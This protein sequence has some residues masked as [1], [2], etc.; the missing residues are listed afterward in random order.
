MTSTDRSRAKGDGLWMKQWIGVAVALALICGCSSKSEKPSQS[1][2]REQSEDPTAQ[3]A[4]DTPKILSQLPEFRL[5]DSNND[6]FGSDELL[7]KVWVANFIFTTCEATCPEQ[8]FWMHQLQEKLSSDPSRGG[9]RLVSITVD[10]DHDTPAVLAEY[11]RQNRADP[12]QWKFLT[13]TRDAIWNLAK[14]GFQLPVQPDPGNTEMPIAHDSKFVVVDRGGNVRAYFDVLARGGVDDVYESLGK[15]IP[16]HFPEGDFGASEYDQ[17]THLAQPPE[18]LDNEWLLGRDADQAG[19]LSEAAVVH[20]F[21][22]VDRREAS[23]ITFKN[24]IVNEQRWRLQVNHYD[25]GN[26]VNAA[27][28]DGDGLL[29]LYFVNQAGRN[30]LWRNL[31]SGKFEDITKASGVALD[32]RICVG[33]SFADTDND[34]DPDLMVTSI[35]GGNAFFENDGKGVF[36]EKTTEAGLEYVGH[37]SGACFF[38]YDRDGKLDLLI[39]NVGK[40]TT[41]EK[42][43]VRND[44]FTRLPEDGVAYFT[45]IKDAFGGHLKPELS[46]RS[47]L[48]RNLG[49]NRFQDVTDDI[50]LDDSSWSGDAVAFDADNDGW[51]DLYVLNM[52]G[53]DEF[54]RNEEG[55]KFIRESESRFPRTP[56]G[57]M[58]ASVLDFNNDGRLDLFVTD[59]HSD[60]SEDIAPDREKLKARMQW[61]ADFLQNPDRAI[62]GNALFI[63]QEDGSFVEK[64]DE[65]GAENYWPWGLS[66]GDLNADGYIDAFLASSMCFPY[67]YGVNSVLLNHGGKKFID[68]EFALKIEPRSGGPTIAPW[69][70]LD[71]DDR[72]LESPLAAGRTGALIV[73]S[74]VGSRSSVLLDLDEDGDLDVV[75]NEFN[76]EPQVLISN[77]TERLELNYIKIRLEGTTTNRGGIGATV[78]VK[79]PQTTQ[80]QLNDGRSGY[81]SQSA[82]P[83]YFGLGASK[84]VDS[85]EVRWPDGK[86]QV[87][88]GPID[89]NQLIAIKQEE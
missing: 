74:A 24:Q 62:Y 68:S 61:P 12:A 34:G 79:T 52:Q 59:M 75:T 71:C 31:G 33:A 20:D 15:I 89:S 14:E 27:D 80:T 42:E 83:L 51:T 1:A 56:W 5:T 26:G 76:T 7:G 73:W 57:A 37:S 84:F 78:A 67:R 17:L 49:D 16:E 70:Q 40:F 54:Y 28:V 29:D 48:Y 13:G 36:A 50:G 65:L 58:G 69:F 19:T 53:T 85:I 39:S 86:K 46:E 11:A 6:E 18:I 60:M 63:Q 41:S 8:T 64:S 32:D 38:D 82:M 2:A 44:R 87:I 3:T 77:L 43:E 47:R 25:H 45:G 55:R 10:P 21:S 4:T 66:S 9:I 30:E 72:D 35:R 23:G 81:L 22:F 88:P